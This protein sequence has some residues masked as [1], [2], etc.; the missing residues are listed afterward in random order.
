[1]SGMSCSEQSGS[2]DPTD[3]IESRAEK[4]DSRGEVFWNE[5]LNSVARSSRK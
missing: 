2:F 5:P 1:M 3:G 4:W